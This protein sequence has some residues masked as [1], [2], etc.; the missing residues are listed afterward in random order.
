MNIYLAGGGSRPYV[1]MNIF[2]AGGITGNIQASWKKLSKEIEE[3][4]SILQERMERSKCSDKSIRGG[5]NNMRL[6]LAGENGK[7]QMRS[8]EHTSELQ[9]P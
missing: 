3:C 7:I 9:S 5:G 8:E 2:L 6:Y 1:I 4:E